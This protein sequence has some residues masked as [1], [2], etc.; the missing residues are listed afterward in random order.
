MRR[1][2]HILALPTMFLKRRH[3]DPSVS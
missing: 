1:T 3:I 2:Q